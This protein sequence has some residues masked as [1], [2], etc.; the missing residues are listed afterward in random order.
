MDKNYGELPILSEIINKR[1]KSQKIIMMWSIPGILLFAG[2]LFWI[3]YTNSKNILIY[4]LITFFTLVFISGLIWSYFQTEK[5]IENV[6]KKAGIDSDEKMEKLL[7]KCTKVSDF[8]FISNDQI[9]DFYKYDVIKIRAI[10]KA[11]PRKTDSD[12]AGPYV[13]EMY[14]RAEGNK[15]VA[16]KKEEERD[17]AYKII[18]AAIDFI[19]RDKYSY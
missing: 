2:F 16:F 1:K 12:D 5:L 3:C 7:E 15:C 6:W 14:V 13:V 18:T 17:R 19:D 4:V 9:I 8:I 11:V 10:T